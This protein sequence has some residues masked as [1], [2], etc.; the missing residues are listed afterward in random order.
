MELEEVAK[1]QKVALDILCE[2]DR[3]CKE[4]DIE[5]MLACGTALG[6]VRHQ[7]FIPWDDDLDIGMTREN[8]Q[9]F[10]EVLPKALKEDYYYHCFEADP[11]YNVL[12]PNM[13]VRKKGTY[14]L[15]R[16]SLLKHRCEGDG[17][18]VD[19]FVYDHISEYRFVNALMRIYMSIF[20]GLLFILDNC[21]LQPVFLKKLFM[22]SA[23]HYHQAHQK[24]R[25][26]GVSMNW[27]FNRPSKQQV[28]R[29]KD[30]FPLQEMLFE[31]RL[32]PM[33][34]NPDA[35]LRVEIGDDY[36]T[37]PPKEKQISKHTVTFSVTS[38]QPEKACRR[39][40]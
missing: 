28:Y 1:I 13:K 19:V 4:N 15:E 3:V 10:L 35:Y 38:D 34:A 36:M 33:P 25:K 30:L 23:Y 12:L 18:F 14:I 31:G 27:I 32:F 16:N 37:L 24:S 9:R 7:G 11:H 29:E 22:N 20:G 2:I 39:E 17:L 40:S 5:Y 26:W 6:A 8:Y 21:H